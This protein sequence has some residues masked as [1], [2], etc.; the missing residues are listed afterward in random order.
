V[1]ERTTLD[2]E[3]SGR[4]P[5]KLPRLKCGTESQQQG[6]GQVLGVGVAVGVGNGR[7]G[8]HHFATGP[9]AVRQGSRKSRASQ[10]RTTNG[11]E[12]CHSATRADADPVILLDLPVV[13]PSGRLTGGSASAWRS[14]GRQERFGQS[15]SGQA[16]ERLMLA[17]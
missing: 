6:A 13:C 10:V 17:H 1:P 14:T 11:C 4:A 9:E 15:A 8:G 12:K 5:G 16:Q 2:E 3:A 7:G